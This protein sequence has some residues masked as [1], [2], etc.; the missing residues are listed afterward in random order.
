M[1][2][3]GFL[4]SWVHP[5]LCAR[6]SRSERECTEL[7]RALGSSTQCVHNMYNRKS[8]LWTLE[9]LLDIFLSVTEVVVN[10]FFLV[11]LLSNKGENTN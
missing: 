5:F 3:E 6:A 10:I 11:V 4:A 8:L 1:K 2:L 7:Q 9:V